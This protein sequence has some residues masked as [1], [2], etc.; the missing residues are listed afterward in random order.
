MSRL[1][2]KPSQ[3]C[4]C[5]QGRVRARGAVNLHEVTRPEI[6]DLRGASLSQQTLDA[7]QNN[8]SETQK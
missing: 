5:Q 7:A 4:L 1:Q 2:A 3:E 8:L 6:E